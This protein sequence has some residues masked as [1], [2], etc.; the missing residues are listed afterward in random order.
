MSAPLKRP[1]EAAAYGPAPVAD[2]WWAETVAAEHWGALDGDAETDV[3]VIGGGFTGLSAA[4][5]LAEAGAGVTLLE[6][7]TPH[8]GASGRNGGFCCLGGAKL[9]NAALDR[10]VGADGRR[11]WR[12]AEKAAVA[13]VS[14]LLDRHGIDADRHSEGET[15]LAHRPRDWAGFAEAA[16]QVRSGYGVKPTLIPKDALAEHGLAGPFHGAMTTPLGFA[17]NPRKYLSGLSRAARGAGATLHDRSPVTRIEGEGPFVLHTPQGRLRAG[18]LVLA[19][20]GYSSDDLPGWMAGR[21]LPLQSSVIVT[22]PI[23]PEERAA[24]GWTS[25]QMAYDTRRLLHYFRLM[26]DGRLLFGMRGGLSQHPLAVAAN[27][28]AIRGHFERMFPAWRGV[29]TPH[30]WSGLVCFT[31]HRAPYAG[32]IPGLRHAVAGFAYHGNG[33]AMGSYTGALLAQM[34]TG[35]DT[36]DHPAILRQEPK[37]FPLGRHRRALMPPVY[38]GYALRDL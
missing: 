3:A 34:L 18:R 9:G 19:T 22:R 28:R 12:D 35:G 6:A 7:E 10:R 4:L 37:R 38:A 30:Y 13:L 1:W 27:R 17:L 31:R 16:A 20:G 36:L 14:D 29:E 33:V 2:C 24:A 23:T 21:F 11:A 26:P 25:G 8:W 5:H 15:L 32:P